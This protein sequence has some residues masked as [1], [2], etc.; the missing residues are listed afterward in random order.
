MALISVNMSL[1]EKMP[2]DT[3]KDLVPVSMLTTTPFVMAAPL[4]SK[5][6]SVGEVIALAKSSPTACRSGHAATEPPC[7]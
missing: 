4:S 5:V 2:Y 7:T 3:L 6:N 1:Q